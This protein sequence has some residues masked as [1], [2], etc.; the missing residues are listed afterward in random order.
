MKVVNYFLIFGLLKNAAANGLEEKSVKIELTNVD[1]ENPP[2]EGATLNVDKTFQIQSFCLRFY[3]DNLRDQCIFH[4]KDEKSFALIFYFATE[5]GFVLINGQWLI[6]QVPKRITPYRY[7]HFCFSHNKTHY[8]VASEGELWFQAEFYDKEI[9]YVVKDVV[10]E[11]FIFGPYLT[12]ISN[13]GKYFTGKIAELDIFS[14]SFSEEE[15]TS[16]TK[17]CQRIAIGTKVLDWSKIRQSEISIPEDTPI[18]TEM[19]EIG[20]VC[21]NQ[22]SA[23]ETKILP[24]SV[25]AKDANLACKS[26]GAKLFQPKSIDDFDNVRNAVKKGKKEFVDYLHDFCDDNG[27]L[28]IAKSEDYKDWIDY[29]DP[30]QVLNI[31]YKIK[32]DGK[33]VQK[34]V[35]MDFFKDKVVDKACNDKYCF[36]CVWEKRSVVQ[37]HGLCPRSVIED[38]YIIKDHFFADGIFCKFNLIHYMQIVQ[39]QA[40]TSYIPLI[41]L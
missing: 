18:M 30:T 12:T 5:Y 13:N 39:A 41:Q 28:A 3:V 11:E 34:C 25:T 19:D 7:S 1:D 33:K 32:T 14:N 22:K 2:Q 31:G 8:M 24:F 16:I 10:V 15:L 9:P 40:N 17:N 26:L 35:A 36:T 27:W 23:R 29:E 4:T 37:L 38:H 21:S 6:F 20:E